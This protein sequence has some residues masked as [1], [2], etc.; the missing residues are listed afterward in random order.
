M[1]DLIV[2]Y[3]VQKTAWLHLQKRLWVLLTNVFIE[4]CSNKF[5]F[6]WRT[7]ILS[8]P[9]VLFLQ[10]LVGKFQVIC[11]RVVGNGLVTL[12]PVVIWCLLDQDSLELSIVNFPWLHAD[13]NQQLN[14]WAQL[15]LFNDV[16]F[17]LRFDFLHQ[18]AY[19]TLFDLG[20][21]HNLVFELTCLHVLNSLEFE[22]GYKVLIHV[23]QDIFD[24]D[25]A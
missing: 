6:G 15:S 4:K 2:L 19:Q 24:H 9:A 20:V 25:D 23:K 1:L 11:T 21:K 7:Q 17:T 10:T 18:D 13:L 3:H 8:D 22:L 5:R 16:A 14:A 12:K